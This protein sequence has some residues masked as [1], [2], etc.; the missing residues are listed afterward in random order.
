MTD[1]EIDMRPSHPSS[2]PEGFLERVDGAV[3]QRGWSTDPERLAPHLLETWGAA[4]GRASLLLRPASTKEVAALLTL[5]HAYRVPVV[6]QGGNTGL[7]VR[8]CRIPAVAW[9]CCRCPA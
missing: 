8:A 7:C 2:L 5:C 3:G 1:A 6:P 9:S 4:R